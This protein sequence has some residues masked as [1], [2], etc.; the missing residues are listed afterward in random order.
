M[1]ILITQTADVSVV[2]RDIQKPDLQ[3]SCFAHGIPQAGP[4]E[5]WHF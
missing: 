2:I 4:S 3:N 1:G 5:H